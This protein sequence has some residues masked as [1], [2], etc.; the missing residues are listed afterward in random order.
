MWGLFGENVDAI[1]YY[2]SEIEKI[3]EEVSLL[4]Y[5]AMLGCYY[6][7][8]VTAYRFPLYFA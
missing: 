5:N 1:D 7:F 4:L 6:S 3:N 2:T 8:S